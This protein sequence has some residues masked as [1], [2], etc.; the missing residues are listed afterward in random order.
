MKTE[1]SEDVLRFW[2]LSRLSGDQAAMVRQ[3]EWWFR[4]GA[5]ADTTEHF[6]P[7]L[8]RATRGAFGKLL[9]GC[10]H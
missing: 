3:W 4:G 10:N 1:R 7:L 9:V 8:E 5:D 2:F 6:S